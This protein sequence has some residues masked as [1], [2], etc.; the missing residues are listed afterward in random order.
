MRA[1]LVGLC[2]V[3]A[4]AAQAQD[5][6][7]PAVRFAPVDVRVECEG[8]TLAAYQLELIVDGEARIVGVEGGEPEAFRA[9]PYYDPAALQRGRIVIAA[10]STATALP[11]S[12]PRLLTLH[13]RETDQ[14]PR[15]VLKVHASVDRDGQAI[16][17]RFDL[18]HRSTP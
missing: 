14:A 2:A 6:A 12:S 15:H 13:L 8:G 18:S 10:F 5:A 9:A 11:S 7:T 3:L 4:G 1:P 17:C 16:A